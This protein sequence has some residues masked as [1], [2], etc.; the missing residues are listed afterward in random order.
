MSDFD[1]RARDWDKDKNHTERSEA[2]ASELEK[3]V[4]LNHSMKALEYG[5]GTGLLSFLLKDKLAEITLMDSSAEMIKVCE[6]KV[7]YYGTT[8]IKPRWTDLEHTD[9]D[10]TFDII[11]HQMVLHHVNDV[12]AILETFYTLLNTGGYLAIA[13]LYTEDGSF[14]GPEVKVHWGFDPAT[15]AETLRRVGFRNIEY[16][17]CFVLKREFGKDYPIFLLVAQ[18]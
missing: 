9:Y 8:N 18:K 5:A 6:E 1:N 10:E 17:T 16:K 15:I 3:M 7:E 12:D 11:Y 4:P 14:H 2:I 13:D